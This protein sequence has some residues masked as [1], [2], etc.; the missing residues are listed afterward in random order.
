MLLNVLILLKNE[1]LRYELTM[2]GDGPDQPRLMEL[3]SIHQLPVKFNGRIPREEFIRIL[4][5]F[6]VLVQ[7]SRL[8]N[9]PFSVIEAMAS[10]CAVIC[11]NV[12][13][14]KGNRTVY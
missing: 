3:A 11:S 5:T 13:G 8:E 14:M 1:G 6:D 10:G 9:F 2:F 7:P 12:N 4:P